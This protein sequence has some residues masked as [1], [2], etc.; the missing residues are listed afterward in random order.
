[1]RTHK[2]LYPK[3]VSFQNLLKAT[4]LSQR[5][6]RFKNPVARFNFFLEKELWRLHCELAEKRYE[7]GPYRHFA[8]YEPK[9]RIISAAPY[10]DRVVHHAIHNVLEPVFEPTFISDSYATRKGKGTHAAID[11]FQE[12]A[13]KN[14]YI[15][16]CDIRKYFPSINQQILM[17]L[18]KRKV[19]CPDT[20]WLVQKVLDSHHMMADSL[21][22]QPALAGI[23][24]GNL[25]SQF[26]ANIYLNGLDH[27]IKENFGCRFYLR[28]MDDFAVFHDDKEFL[29]FVKEVVVQ[30]LFGLRLHLHENKCRIFKTTAG[31]PFL[32]MIL[33]PDN[34][35]LKHDNVIRFK[36]RLKRFQKLYKNGPEKWP[37]IHQSILSWIGHASHADTSRL[38]NLILEEVVF[39]K[40]KG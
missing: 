5:C 37:H 1:M 7:P 16:K 38:R 10:R 26:F 9:K 13:K 3:I 11:R 33:F 6:K 14:T 28:Y 20:L 18:I 39:R 22:S 23:P 8:I 36:K 24:I 27:F 15:L 19:A 25:T 40:Q 35:R 2:N 32:G 29:W 17:R 31:T 21:H 30:Y 12:F 34:R 4:R